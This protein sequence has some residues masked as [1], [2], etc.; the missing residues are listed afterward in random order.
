[1]PRPTI[2]RRLPLTRGLSAVR[3]SGGEIRA[4]TGGRPY[5]EHREYN[6][7]P[8][9]VASP[10]PTG[11]HFSWRLAVLISF[12]SLGDFPLKGEIRL[13]RR[14][15]RARRGRGPGRP[16]LALWANSPSRA[17]RKW[18]LLPVLPAAPRG[19]TGGG[20]SKRVAQTALWFC[21][22]VATGGRRARCQR[23]PRAGIFPP[24]P[25]TKLPS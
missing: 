9:A 5:R 3:L 17:P 15:G 7:E 25:R 2:P 16:L 14:R 11:V 13:G 18:S 12:V 24:N 6:T 20:A 22:T 10:R 1:M 8:M 23:P 4:A 19:S 21:R